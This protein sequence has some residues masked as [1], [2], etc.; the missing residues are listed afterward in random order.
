MGDE[1]RSGLFMFGPG[2]LREEYLVARMVKHFGPRFGVW[3]LVWFSLAWYGTLS[4]HTQLLRVVKPSEPCLLANSASPNYTQTVDS[5]NFFK[6]GHMKTRKY[7]SM[8]RVLSFCPVQVFNAEHPCLSF[9]NISR[10][11][12]HYK[13]I[14][15]SSKTAPVTNTTA[16]YG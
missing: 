5:T 9:A 13:L 7:Q 14:V 8:Q 4:G 16:G 10:V 2:G 6:E 11:V 3:S 12:H 1:N 15:Y